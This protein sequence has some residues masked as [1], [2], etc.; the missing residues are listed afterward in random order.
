MDDTQLWLLNIFSRS[1]LGSS[2]YKNGWL[3]GANAPSTNHQS[4]RLPPKPNQPINSE[5]SQTVAHCSIN[6]ILFFPDAFKELF[7]PFF[8]LLPFVDSLQHKPSKKNLEKLS[9]RSKQKLLHSVPIIDE[10]EARQLTS[11]A[12]H[13]KSHPIRCRHILTPGPRW[14][15]LGLHP[16]GNPSS[17]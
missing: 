7:L 9:C 2:R 1:F 11:A 15:G 6:K 10:I 5:Y 4:P 8:F 17:R 14:L 12:Y 3:C 16:R 13:R